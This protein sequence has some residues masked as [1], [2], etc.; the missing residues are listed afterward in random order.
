MHNYPL[1]Y[2]LVKQEI[3]KRKLN[4]I[5]WFSLVG[6]HVIMIIVF[7]LLSEYNKMN[8]LI[9]AIIILNFVFIMYS[10]K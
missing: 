10:K 5:Q 1:K 9:M 4:Y 2:M 3:D 7:V 8:L 6:I